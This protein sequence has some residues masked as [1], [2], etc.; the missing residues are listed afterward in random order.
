MVDYNACL[1]ELIKIGEDTEKN[2]WVTKDKLKRLMTVAVPGTALGI[3]TS[4]GARKLMDVAVRKGSPIRRLGGKIPTPILRK[5]APLI[6]G[7]AAAG[8]GALFMHH[9]NKAKKLLEGDKK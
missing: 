3:A 9:R 2:K 6:L 4:I 8:S 7:A 1:D 5:Y